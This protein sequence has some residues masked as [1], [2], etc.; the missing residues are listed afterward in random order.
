MKIY[1]NINKLIPELKKITELIINDL[2][3]NSIPMQIFETYRIL[4]RQKELIAKGYSKTLKSK[5]LIG[6]AVD[7]VVFID[8]KWSWNYAKYSK[9][10]NKYGEIAEGYGLKW[11][12]R[13]ESFK[14]YPHIE[15]K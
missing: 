5:H 2:E 13:W 10:F 3:L 12:G 15:I 11:G 14:D 8:G 1:R 7:F 6:K 4:N 9:Y